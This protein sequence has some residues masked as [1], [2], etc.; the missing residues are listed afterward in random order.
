MRV[1]G[2]AAILLASN[3]ALPAAAADRGCVT[4][5]LHDLIQEGKDL[6]L[7]ELHGTVESPANP[8]FSPFQIQAEPP[9]PISPQGF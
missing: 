2:V 5:P 8:A 1:V 4:T 7:G 3:V 6:Y 9:A